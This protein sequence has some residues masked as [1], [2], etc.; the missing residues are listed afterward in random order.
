MTVVVRETR[1]TTVRV[2]L[3]GGAGTATVDT[4]TPFLDHNPHP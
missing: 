4:G 1:E 3:K 2:E